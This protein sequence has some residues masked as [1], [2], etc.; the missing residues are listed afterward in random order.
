M[1]IS[2]I[3]KIKSLRINISLKLSAIIATS[4]AITYAVFSVIIYFDIKRN[5][6]EDVDRVINAHLDNLQNTLED[7]VY[8]QLK[9]NTEP[10]LEHDR[11]YPKLKERYS[12]KTF[13]EAGYLYVM[14]SKGQLLI[15]PKKDDGKNISN[16]EHGHYIITANQPE[17]KFSYVSEDYSKTVHLEYYRYF[18]AYD[19]YLVASCA[20]DDAFS[21]LFYYR[22]MMF[23][24]TLIVIVFLISIIYYINRQ[25]ASSLNMISEVLRKLA[26]GNLESEFEYRSN[27]EIKDIEVSLHKLIDGLK[28]TTQF[29]NDIANNELDTEFEPLSEED[30]LGQSLIDMRKKIKV[31]RKEEVKRKQEE[32]EQRWINQGL[33]KFSDILRANSDDVSTQGDNIIQNLVRYVGANQGGI[34]VYNNEDD[35]NHHLELIAAFAYD[36]KKFMQKTIPLGEGLIGTC[37]IER[38]TIYLTEVPN[39]YFEITSGLGDAQPNSILI[40]PI[41]KDEELLGVIELA[42]FKNF[43]K[44]EIDFVEKIMD[45][46]AATLA[47]LKI[48]ARTQ[49]LL[50]KFEKQSSE[51]AEKEADMRQNIEELQA[52]QEESQKKEHSFNKIVSLFKSEMYVVEYDTS[53]LVIDVSDAYAS[54]LQK[55]KSEILGNSFYDGRQLT[56]DERRE[57][58]NKWKELLNGV[59]F[60]QTIRVRVREGVRFTLEEKYYPLTY[61]NGTVYKILKVVRDMTEK[62]AMLNEIVGK[63]KEIS[64]LKDQINRL[65][66]E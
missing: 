35:F 39:G 54:L 34:F 47:S 57:L 36:T 30:V 19:L 31:N 65:S 42:S 45:S 7:I 3:N 17:G 40:V 55:P 8:D 64:S 62:E 6:E 23:L 58:G 66:S 63:N 59:E 28:L 41:K 52:V 22:M 32:G 27:D 46:V 13:F 44:F 15:H 5:L 26:I 37:A 14:D 33:A 1:N 61:A 60:V 16:T 21:R 53:G 20:E 24:G 25:F 4:V 18:E 29:S 9:T 10:Y 56:S 2:L 49:E 51:M 38:E 11:V 43:A 12:E 48:N 50:T